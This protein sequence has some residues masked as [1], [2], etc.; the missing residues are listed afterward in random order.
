M[1]RKSSR[2]PLAGIRVVELCDRLGQYAGRLLA[3]L[4]ADVVKVEPPGG[5]SARRIGPFKDGVPHP[6]RSLY[7]AN[8]NTNKR[9]LVLDVGQPAD[10]EAFRA[11]VRTADAL[12]E[13]FPP[14][15]LAANGLGYDDLRRINPRLILTS[16]TPFGQTGPYAAYLGPDI[17]AFALAG[18]M[19]FNGPPDRAPLVGPCEQGYQMASAHAAYATLAALYRR[20]ESDEGQWIDVSVQET[21][22]SKPHPQILARYDFFG[23]IQQRQGSQTT[24]GVPA[25]IYPCQDG[26]VSYAIFNSRDHWRAFRRMI[27]EPAALQDEIW[28]DQPYRY[29]NRDVVEI[30]I[31]EFTAPRTR[32][33]LV[34]LGQ[35]HHI[36][37]APLNRLADYAAD[38]QPL[39]RGFFMT[40]DHP[41]IGRYRSVGA[42]ARLS[43]T[44]WALRRPA[45]LLDQHRAEILAEVEG[46]GEGRETG[47]G[48]RAGGTPALPGPQPLPQDWGRGEGR[49]P[50][51]PFTLHP[52]PFTLVGPLRGVRVLD[53]TH[54]VAGPFGSRLLA[55]LGAQVIKV[56][57]EK[58]TERSNMAFQLDRNKMSISVDMGT[59]AGRELIRRLLPLCDVVMENF[60]LRVMRRWG[61]DYPRIREVNPSIV[62]MSMQGLGQTG[63]KREYVTWGPNLLPFTG[64][65]S[66]WAYPDYEE[67]GNVLMNAPLW[68]YPDFSATIHGVTALTAALHHRWQAGEGQHI[69]LAQV[70]P[71]ACLIGTAYLDHFVNGP[72]AWGPLGNAHPQFAPYGS[73]PCLGHDRW[74]AIAVETDEQWAHLVRLLGD[75]PWSEGARFQ[76]MAARVEHRAELDEHVAEWTRSHTPHQAMRLLQK[77]GVPAGAVQDAEDIYFDIHLRAR[78]MLP[79]VLHPGFAEPHPEPGIPFKFSATPVRI[80]HGSPTLGQHN[81]EI[82]AG[83]LGLSERE[84]AALADQGVLR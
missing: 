69:D 72:K 33:E 61:L 43:G 70:E 50:S 2:P 31:L 81:E 12:L 77:A 41:E 17:V 37:T 15:H 84:I 23:E 1:A 47:D 34:E 65:T 48:R 18:V 11:L 36:A 82:L 51:L 75:P 6:E 58:V 57:S 28:D 54:R 32:A 4:G 25:A 24:G 71:V 45:P 39:A 73:Y 79:E 56:D 62:M 60:S 76:T 40:A 53:F 52:S 14:G 30:F 7:F 68:A 21:L 13:D 63:P 5:V 46:G 49:G 9:S 16:I 29:A 8:F 26:Y 55:D 22:I 74:C 35:A 38:P 42:P 44:P 78:D 64:M 80:R 83:L 59:E 3:D 19:S 67:T 66:L 10:R 27:G 20:L